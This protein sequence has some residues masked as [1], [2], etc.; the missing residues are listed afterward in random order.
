MSFLFHYFVNVQFARLD[1]VIKKSML[2]VH[3]IFNDKFGSEYVKI[4][5]YGCAQHF[6]V[7]PA[8]TVLETSA[9]K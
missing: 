2:A 5:E 3:Y 6:G 4:L 7:V 9:V 1:R 8:I